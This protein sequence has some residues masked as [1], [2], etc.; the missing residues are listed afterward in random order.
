VFV[1]A[2]FVVWRRGVFCGWL[3]PFGALREFA[4]EASLALRIKQ[5]R[6]PDALD[7]QLRKRIM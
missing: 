6:V 1:L 4:A 7:V 5:W 3:C 2:T